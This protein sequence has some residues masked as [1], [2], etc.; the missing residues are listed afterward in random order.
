VLCTDGIRKSCA[1]DADFLTLAAWLARSAIE[2]EPEA[3]GILPAALDR[4]SREGSGDDVTVAIGRAAAATG[5]TREPPPPPKSRK[6]PRPQGPPG[7][8]LRRR[9][10]LGRALAVALALSGAGGALLA[11]SWPRDQPHPAAVPSSAGLQAARDEVER[12]CARPEAIPLELRRRRDLFVA[13]RQRRQDP[14]RLKAAAATDPLAALIA[15]DLPA[16]ML[17]ASPANGSPPPPTPK[18]QAR[19]EPAPEPQ[20]GPEQGSWRPLLALGACPELLGALE[21]QWAVSLAGAAPA[22][23]SGAWRPS[24]PPP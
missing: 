6:P 18:T 23:E 17:P 24:L 15:A 16:T 10:A 8:P 21:R 9:P 19:P 20:A 7:P 12:L 4:I 14:G 5:A 2:E 3:A 1:T 22:G 11:L 13:L